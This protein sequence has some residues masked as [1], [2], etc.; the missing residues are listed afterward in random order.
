M[1]K[2]AV[3][4][5]LEDHIHHHYQSLWDLR[6]WGIY[7]YEALLRH[8]YFENPEHFF[9]YARK[10][11]CLST[12]DTISILQAIESLPFLRDKK[13]FVNV[14][15]STVINHDFLTFI[16][17]V[18]KGNPNIVRQVV[19]ELN[20]SYAEEEI[21]HI[22]QLKNMVERIKNQGFLIAMDD[23]GKGAA[24]LQ[25]IIEF[26]PDYIK[27][28]RYF[29]TELSKN[30][31]KQAMVSFLVNYC[32]SFG[33]EVVLEGIETPVDLAMAKVLKVRFGQGYVLERPMPL[34]AMKQSGQ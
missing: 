11:N 21:W 15:P 8:E 10:N 3:A 1:D 34:E 12:L 27:L 2:T 25:K 7:G 23:V 5:T 9:S 19:F 18:K 31:E 22:P 32:K 17:S 33:I 24:S 4:G 13:L 16:E 6:E 14:F 29:S 30:L 20:E 28:D 26:K